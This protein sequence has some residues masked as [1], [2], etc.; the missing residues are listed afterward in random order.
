MNKDAAK[1]DSNFTVAQHELLHGVLQATWKKNP[2]IISGLSQML[3]DSGLDKNA[4]VK[5]R[6]QSYKDKD[7][8]IQ[9][10]EM[11]TILSD[12]ITQGYIK[13]DEGFMS[14]LGDGF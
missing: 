5:Y 13:Y 8:I 4:Y 12:G 11:L 6:M 14:K 2:N 1:R 7:K 9:D 3:K 10:E